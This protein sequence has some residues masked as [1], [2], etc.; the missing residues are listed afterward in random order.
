M[1]IMYAAESSKTMLRRSRRWDER[2]KS[3]R[4]SSKRIKQAT[5][6]VQ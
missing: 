1:R 5:V 3:Q 4:I 6:A 2:S